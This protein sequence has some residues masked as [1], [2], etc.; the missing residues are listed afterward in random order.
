[1]VSK[2][3]ESCSARTVNEEWLH[4]IVIRAVNKLLDSGGDFLPQ[5]K[6]NIEKGLHSE[7]QE[8]VERI[9]AKLL[10]LQEELIRKANARQDY[11]GTAE[12]I[13]R[14]RA[15]KDRLLLIA[16][17]KENDRQRLIEIA[18]FLESTPSKITEYDDILVRRLIEKITVFDHYFLVEFKTGAEFKIIG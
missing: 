14:L 6:E 3:Y 7:E 2:K 18:E 1:M 16:A 8:E 10:L 11:E 15:E 13:E 9:D 4:D 17:G 5:L 12:E